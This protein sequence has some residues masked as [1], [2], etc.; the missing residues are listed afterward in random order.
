MRAAGRVVL[1]TGGGRGIGAAT[2]RLAAARGDAVAVN[3][4]TPHGAATLVDELRAAG[5]TAE[6]FVAD[7]ADEAQVVGMFTTVETALGPV[8]ALVNCAGIAAAHGPLA[9]VDAA[10]LRR[11][12]EVNVLGT[13]LCCREAARRMSIARGGAGG[14]IVN[15]SS[16]AAATGG[17]E[18]AAAYAASKAAIDAFT[19]GLAKELAPQGVRVVA[20]RPGMT[21]T[22]MTAHVHAVPETATKVARSIPMGRLA[23]ADE[24]AGPILW[25]LSNEASF[26]TGALLDVSGGGFLIR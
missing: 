14:A 21:V 19:T 11:L 25:L 22:D 6:M 4:R 9:D 7:V 26:V 8:T 20:V 10:D 5:G 3:A 17:R 13:M 15:L 23:S 16:M 24:I 2:A 18:G 12:L 1:I